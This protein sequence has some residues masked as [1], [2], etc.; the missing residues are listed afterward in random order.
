MEETSK[1]TQFQAPAMG[2]A[3][4]PS[5]AAQGPIQHGLEHLQG[6]GTTAPGQLCQHLTAL[7]VKKFLLTSNLNLSSFSLKPSTPYPITISPCESS[8]L[9]LLISPLKF[10]KT[11]VRSPCS[12]LFFKLNKPASLG[13][14]PQES[15]SRLL[16]ISSS[17]LYCAG[18]FH[19]TYA[20]WHVVSVKLFFRLEGKWCVLEINL[21]CTSSK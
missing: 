7:W 21:L 8:L 10:W 15:C 2:R 4:L 13:F 17:F 14:P 5:S 12:L 1:P 11:T 9:F 18:D 3:A 6:W 19:Y 16:S 20:K